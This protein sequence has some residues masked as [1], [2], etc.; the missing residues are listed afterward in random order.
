M[1]VARAFRNLRMDPVNALKFGIHWQGKY[2]IDKEVTFGWVHGSLA[3]Q[4]TSDAIIYIM[5]TKNHHMWAYIDDYILIGSKEAT[6]AVFH[7]LSS[8]LTELGLP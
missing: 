5:K 8:L 2:F 7:D 4:M 6:E 3:F 1:D